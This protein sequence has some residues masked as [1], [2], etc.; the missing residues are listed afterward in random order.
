MARL[1]RARQR[2]TRAVDI[3]AFAA[4]IRA[5]CGS[6]NR[7][8]WLTLHE[9]LRSGDGAFAEGNPQVHVLM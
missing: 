5:L 6:Q 2:R 9:S 7:E 1:P 8:E 3:F 4:R